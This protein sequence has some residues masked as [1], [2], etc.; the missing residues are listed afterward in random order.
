MAP[1]FWRKKRSSPLALAPMYEAAWLFLL[2][3]IYGATLCTVTCLPYIGPYILSTGDGFKDGLYSSLAFL[4]GKLITY[5][6][7]GGMAAYLGAELLSNNEAVAKY[8]TGVI[9]IAVGASLFIARKNKSP[10]GRIQ[11]AATRAPL[12]MLGIST[13]MLPC[14]AVIAMFTFAIKSGS[15]VYGAIYGG[16]YGA[17]VAMSPLLIIG[18]GV[19]MIAN[20]LKVE[21]HRTMPYL[22]AI[23][24][25]LIALMG[26]KILT[27]GA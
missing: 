17:G 7:M 20:T 9:L 10:C 19:S 4:A 24:G 23:S 8:I 5:M 6:I 1:Q 12:V 21:V 15:V 2:G 22:R 26:A 18:G 16:V 25:I 3:V 27:A 14:P 11:K 13:S